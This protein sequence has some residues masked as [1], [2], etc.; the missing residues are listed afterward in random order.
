MNIMDF[1]RPANPQQQQNTQ[2]GNVPLNQSTAPS[3][4]NAD[5][6]IQNQN[7]PNNTVNKEVAD[8]PVDPL[9]AMEDIWK[10][11]EGAEKNLPQSVADFAFNVKQED[12]LKNARAVDF[13]KAIP[14]DLLAKVKAGGEEGMVAMLQAMNI[15]GQ[16]A[17]ASA[18]MVAAKTTEAG[19]RNAGTQIENNLPSFIK[20]ETISQTLREDNPLFASPA[21]APMVEMLEVQLQAKHPNA[22]PAQ[23]KE[24]ARTYFTTM[25]AE[26]A[27]HLGVNSVN[28][29]NATQNKGAGDYDWSKEPI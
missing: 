9:K 29:S 18:S 24:H 20:R 6:N 2:T 10:L 8:P 1:F 15:V 14:T 16:Q 4:P 21:V 22:T 11:P 23:I 26:G 3:N 27:K 25:I 17:F 13:T 7:P 28:N 19:I 5:P 12:V